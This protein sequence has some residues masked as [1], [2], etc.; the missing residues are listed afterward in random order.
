MTFRIGGNIILANRNVSNPGANPAKL[1]IGKP[2]RRLRFAIELTV[3]EPHR[4]LVFRLDP[5]D[6]GQDLRSLG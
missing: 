4:S 3:G 6:R 1:T 5:L 2:Q